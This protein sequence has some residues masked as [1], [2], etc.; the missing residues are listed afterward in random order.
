MY[1]RMHIVN[2]FQQPSSTL[3]QCDV[4]VF[5]TETWGVLS[6]PISETL[7]HKLPFFLPMVTAGEQECPWSSIQECHQWGLLTRSWG[8]LI[9]RA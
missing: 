8:Q 6:S 5:L 9:P 1:L 3:K 2:W 4:L 7:K